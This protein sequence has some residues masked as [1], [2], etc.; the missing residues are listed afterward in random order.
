V[1]KNIEKAYIRIEHSRLQKLVSVPSK[2]LDGSCPVT[3]SQGAI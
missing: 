2:I 3:V 1:T